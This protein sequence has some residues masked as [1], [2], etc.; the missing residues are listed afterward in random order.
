MSAAA[1]S[2]VGG[3]LTLNVMRLRTFIAL[4]AVVLFFSFVAP[5]FL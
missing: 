2:L 4:F 1:Q 3:S 5:N